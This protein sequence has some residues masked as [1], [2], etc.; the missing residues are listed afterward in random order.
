MPDKKP[1]DE[2]ISEEKI[3]VPSNEEVLEVIETPDEI[4]VIDVGNK[5]SAKIIEDWPEAK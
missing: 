4:D 1:S 3:V 2:N 5:E